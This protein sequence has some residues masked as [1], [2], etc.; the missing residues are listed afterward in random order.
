MRNVG[1]K[2]YHRLNPDS[3]VNDLQVIWIEEWGQI[4]KQQVARLIANM[5][6]HCTECIEA[7]G[8]H[9]VIIETFFLRELYVV[10]L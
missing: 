7:V 2:G 10:K 5:L 6:C 9:T 8:G 4:T 3:T 1:Q